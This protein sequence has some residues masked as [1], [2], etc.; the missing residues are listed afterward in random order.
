MRVSVMDRSLMVSRR[1]CEQD[2]GHGN[3]SISTATISS[4]ASFFS[5]FYLK[6]T[7]SVLCLVRKTS[8]IQALQFFELARFALSS[9]H[10]DIPRP[11]NH[12]A[13]Y[14]TLCRQ[15]RPEDSAI[16]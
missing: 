5:A 1:P 14:R 10:I 13:S 9:V 6:R 8:S 11:N 16:C 12:N 15:S 4:M 7:P 3:D 2:Q